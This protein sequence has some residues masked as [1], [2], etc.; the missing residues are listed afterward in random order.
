MDDKNKNPKAQ[1]S[2][3]KIEALRIFLK[4]DIVGENPKKLKIR[5][6]EI[7]CLIQKRSARDPQWSDRTNFLIGLKT[8]H[9]LKFTAWFEVNP[10]FGSRDIRLL[11]P[12]GE[13]FPPPPPSALG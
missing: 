3:F 9:K 5:Y 1:P 4:I 13:S 2:T 7:R 8:N 6:L 10:T 12:G 11:K